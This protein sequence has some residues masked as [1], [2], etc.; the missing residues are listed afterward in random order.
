LVVGVEAR[1]GNRY[2]T[3]EQETMPV[4]IPKSVPEPLRGCLM[5]LRLRWPAT[6][7]GLQRAYR[8]MVLEAHPDRGGTHEKFLAVGQARE[9]VAKAIVALTYQ[10]TTERFNFHDGREDGE[11][12]EEEFEKADRSDP[13]PSR[14]DFIQPDSDGFE[15]YA[16]AAGNST[17]MWNGRRLTIFRREGH[18]KWCVAEK[19]GTVRFNQGRGWSTFEGAASDLADFLGI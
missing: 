12:A 15:W 5:L 19:D 1:N 18:F 9:V 10:Q 13:W 16:S 17:R 6:E 7:E 8:R 11:D 4:I 3:K 14:D 2:P